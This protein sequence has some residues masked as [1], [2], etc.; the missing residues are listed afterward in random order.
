MFIYSFGSVMNVGLRKCRISVFCT[1][2]LV[3]FLLGTICGVLLFRLLC[4]DQDRWILTYSRILSAGGLPGS[5]LF[6]WVRPLIVAVLPGLVPWGKRVIPVLVLLRGLLM[7]YLASALFA[8]GLPL[9]GVVLRGATMLPLFFAVSFWSY[10]A[11][12]LGRHV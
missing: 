1:L 3:L 9:G 6:S 2:F 12:P 7:A 10:H 11:F 5:R 4:S 8:C